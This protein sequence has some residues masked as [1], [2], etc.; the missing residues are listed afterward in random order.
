MFGKLLNQVWHKPQPK[1]IQASEKRDSTELSKLKD[2]FV[3][4]SS[5]Y[6]CSRCCIDGK[7]CAKIH[8]ANKTICV[9]PKEDA[10]DLVRKIKKTIT[11]KN[12]K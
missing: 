2:L 1:P 4:R 10:G 3:L 5:N 8:F 11:S 7:T 12:K 9:C 6:P